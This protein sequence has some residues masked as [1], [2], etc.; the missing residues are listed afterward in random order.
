[1]WNCEIIKYGAVDTDGKNLYT[2]TPPATVAYAGVDGVDGEDG[3]SPYF[4]SLSDNF[5]P[6][7]ASA[8][9]DVK[10]PAN[11]Y[12]ITPTIKYGVDTI[13]DW[14]VAKII[15]NSSTTA[16]L[17]LFAE[18]T[19]GISFDWSSKNLVFYGMTNGDSVKKG[20]ITFKL[21]YKETANSTA[22]IVAE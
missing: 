17:H 1:L 22:K 16:G 10:L 18:S 4:I 6:V 3:T 9:Y 12:K 2:I 19:S 21:Y 20:S 14:N 7:P 8:N 15:P 5:I 11:G 13:T